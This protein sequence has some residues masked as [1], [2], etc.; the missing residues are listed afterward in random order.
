V[1]CDRKGAIHEGRPDLN[2]E[3][4]DMAAL[5]N[6]SMKRG[7]LADVIRG[8]D[9]FIGLSAPGTVSE[10]MVRSMAPNPVIFAMANPVP[11][12]M[13]DLALAAGAS[14]VGTGRSDFPNQINNV[15]AFPGVFR[16]ALDVRSRD[17]N[18]EMKL[19]AAR[20][21]A[22]LVGADELRPEYVIPAPFDPRVAPAV[23]AAVADAA[24]RTGVA[25]L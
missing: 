9:V 17:I 13:P 7:T 11:E 12:I 10:D 14:V 23:A 19:A 24:R 1:L 2:S 3:K 18:D 22:D 5:S 6:R 8:A 16:G 20:A 21:I 15:L 25:R 4:A